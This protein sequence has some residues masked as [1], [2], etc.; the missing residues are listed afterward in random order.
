MKLKN[1]IIYRSPILRFIGLRFSRKNN[2]ILILELRKESRINS[3]I[4]MFFVFYPI[5]VIWLDKNKKVVDIKNNI[6]PFT[7]FVIPRKKAKYI[8]ES[9]HSIKVKP[10]DK[11]K[12]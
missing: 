1:Y 8:L 2:K 4:D 10:G 9:T 3:A 12:F 6:L 7:P 5:N 11:L